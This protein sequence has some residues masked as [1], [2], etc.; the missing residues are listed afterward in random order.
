MSFGSSHSSRSAGASLLAR[1]QKG[2]GGKKLKNTNNMLNPP[3][4]RTSSLFYKGTCGSP[5]C[6]PVH[7]LRRNPLPP[8]ALWGEMGLVTPTLLILLHFLGVNYPGEPAA[9]SP[10]R[11]VSPQAPSSWRSPAG[12]GPPWWDPPRE[13]GETDGCGGMREP[14]RWDPQRPPPPRRPPHPPP[15]G[16]GAEDN[17]LIILYRDFTPF[18]PTPRYRS[19]VLLS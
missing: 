10:G 6:P 5:P 12:M 8:Q 13:R 11:C 9:P 15:R 2:K 14:P 3:K 1:K 7:L 17:F 16:W 19:A 4:F 18:V